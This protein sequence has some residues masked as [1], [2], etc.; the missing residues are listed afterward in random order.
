MNHIEMDPLSNDRICSEN[1]KGQ[2]TTYLN[3]SVTTNHDWLTILGMIISLLPFANYKSVSHSLP[4]LV[5]T[6]IQNCWRD[7]YILLIL[8]LLRM[9]IKCLLVQY[10]QLKEEPMRCLPS[11]LCDFLCTKHLLIEQ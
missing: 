7:R 5:L 6:T 2:R 10:L 11:L 3:Y 1:E 8:K 4:H 9:D